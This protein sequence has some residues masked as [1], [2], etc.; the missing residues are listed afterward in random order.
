LEG[1]H[2][3]FDGCL[4]DL[5]KCRELR[6]FGFFGGDSDFEAL[7]LAADLRALS[8]FED[9]AM[10]DM[11]FFFKRVEILIMTKL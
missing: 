2:L 11:M 4:G 1:H 10:D 6:L 9:G 5:R 8:F 7:C 3:H